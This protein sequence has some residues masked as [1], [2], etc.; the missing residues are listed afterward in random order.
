MLYLRVELADLG[1]RLHR[2]IA[3]KIEKNQ[4]DYMIREQIKL[5]RRELGEDRDEREVEIERFQEALAKE[6]LPE[7]VRQKGESE[8]K[9]LSQLSPEATEYNMVR[10]YLE[11]L[12]DL[13]WG[14]FSEDRLD[15]KRSRKIL[16]DEHFGLGQV[17][18]RLIEYLAV[19]IRNAEAKGSIICLCGPPG[20]GKTSIALSIAKG[21]G[22]KLH[23]VSLGGMRDE[24][25]IKGHRRTYVGRCQA[26]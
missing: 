26:S 11:W 2:E 8:L 24:A 5:L 7:D 17:K 19:R 22:R 3:E 13:P 6:G 14:E 1:A 18:D 9:R 25:E 21:M 12:T 20:T 23:R 15:L 4:K 10:T 16:D